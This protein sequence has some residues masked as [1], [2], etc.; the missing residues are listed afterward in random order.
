MALDLV[1]R[2]LRR[3]A[4]LAG[5]ARP[6]WVPRTVV[7]EV[8]YACPLRCVHCYSES[9]R[10]AARHLSAPEVL[11]VAEAIAAIRPAPRVVLSGGEP[12]VVPG[13]LDAVDHLR[14][15]GSAVDLYTSGWG[16][17]ADVARRV[18]DLFTRIGVSID[19]A[20]EE[21]N[22]R[23]RGKRGAF[24]EAAR[25][26]DLFGEIAARRRRRVPFGIEFT[27][28]RSN[29]D[30]VDRFCSDIVPRFPRLAHVTFG[31][32]M[33]EG[34]ASRPDFVDAELLGEADLAALR[35]SKA[36]LRR[37]VPRRV[38][39]EVV[40]NLAYQFRPDQVAR[41]R[42]ADHQMK[43]EPDG[44]VRAMDAYEGTVGNLLEEPAA[45]LWARARERL[46]DPFVTRTLGAIRTSRDWADAT[47]RIDLR[48]ADPD[49]HAR[50]AARMESRS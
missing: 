37:L 11:R 46:A 31:A 14:S 22:D 25:A 19:G 38:R 30:H 20:D 10:R 48:F 26:L 36:R 39:V 15:A 28:M 9:G 44:R 49:D 32:V 40:D 16:L 5:R 43:V 27:V 21:T 24:R 17:R 33:P 8:T 29:R 45:A 2:A 34:F 7:W 23:L 42:A 3:T 50:V 41:A 47:R 4:G 6:W 13:I 35:A 1:R 18:V 12:L